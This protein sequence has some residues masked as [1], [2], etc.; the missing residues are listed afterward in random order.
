MQTPIST[1]N[2][3]ANA[4]SADAIATAAYY[5]WLQAGRPAG[6]DQDFWLKAEAQMRTGASGVK[7]TQGKPAATKATARR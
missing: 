4:S 1:P 7:A 3:P 2:T 5:Q 6:R